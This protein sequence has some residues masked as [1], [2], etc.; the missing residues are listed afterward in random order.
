MSTEPKQTPDAD[1]ETRTRAELEAR[2]YRGYDIWR[3]RVRKLQENV[4]AYGLDPSAGL[5]DPDWRQKLS[6]DYREP[7]IKTSAEEAIAH[8]LRRVYLPLFTILIAAWL[9]RITAFSPESLTATAAVGMIPGWVVVATVAVFYLGAV[10]TA[11][12]P[13]TWYAKGELRSENLRK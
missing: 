6:L 4:F 12:R 10:G 8:R 3:S 11:I 5:V 9:V 2:R 7:T 1:D 13:R